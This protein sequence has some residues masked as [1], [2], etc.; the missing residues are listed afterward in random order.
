L[1][2]QG[3]FYMDG[4]ELIRAFAASRGLRVRRRAILDRNF[5]E[6]LVAEIKVSVDDARCGV[7]ASAG[8]LG[9]EATVRTDLVFSVGE[10]D[11]VSY[12]KPRSFE[13]IPGIAGYSYREEAIGEAQQWL[14][15]QENERIIR[16]LLNEPG[17]AVHVLRAQVRFVGRARA[18]EPLLLRF[19]DLR[20]A[21]ASAS[22]A[23]EQRLDV[24]MLPTDLAAFVRQFGRLAEG[25]D[26][27]RN[28]LCERLTP[29][30]RKIFVLAARPLL[31]ALNRY[32]DTLAGTW[33]DAAI[34]LQQLGELASELAQAD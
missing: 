23:S 9:V 30:E 29:A 27:Q 18:I 16:G 13:A 33:P 15:K 5:P 31:P 4:V 8:Y 11:K 28:E 7:Q 24:G 25:D 20:R 6:L 21:V 2:K 17:D 12:K 3:R 22:D 26:A 32:L 10:P 19:V 1:A 14:A 34:K